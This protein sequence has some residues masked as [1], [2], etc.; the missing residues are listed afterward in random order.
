[1]ILHLAGYH[2]AFELRLNELKELPC[3]T[4]GTYYLVEVPLVK[5][6]PMNNQE[7]ATMLEKMKMPETAIKNITSLLN[8]KPA[9]LHGCATNTPDLGTEY[10][11]QRDKEILQIIQELIKELPHEN[12]TFFGGNKHANYIANNIEY[13]HIILYDLMYNQKEYVSFLK[14]IN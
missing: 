5:E 12:I 14:G 9:R 7:L 3:F 4:P 13:P 8:L 1:M 2:D 6:L 10:G 11:S